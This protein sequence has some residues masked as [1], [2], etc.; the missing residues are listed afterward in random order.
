M[1]AAPPGLIPFVLRLPN[2]AFSRIAASMLTIDPA[3]RSSMADDLAA[4]RPTEID[5]LAGAIVRL[6]EANGHSAPANA[7]VTRLIK[8][9]APGVRITGPALLAALTEP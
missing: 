1:G 7:A 9:H 5:D 8:G 6:A 4:G 3:A 2:W